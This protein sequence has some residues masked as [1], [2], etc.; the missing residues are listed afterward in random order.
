M[1]DHERAT[2]HRVQGAHVASGITFSGF[3]NVD[4]NLI[5]NAIMQQE[6][7]PLRALE[8]Q[9]TALRSRVTT[10]TLLANRISALEDAARA[11]TGQGA[12]SAFTATSTDPA[13]VG[14]SAGSLA[15]AGRYDIVV[16]E[17]ARAQVTAST[18]TTPDADT[19]VVADGGTLTIGGEA[20]AISGPMTLAELADAINAA[21]DAPARASIVQ[22]APGTFRLVL[23]ARS[24]GAANGFI[25]TN[26]LT[27]GA[28]ITFADTDGNGVSGDSPADNAVQATDAQILVNNIPVTSASNTLD[29]VI[30]GTTLTLYRRDPAATIVVDVAV[31]PSVLRSRLDAFV[32]AYNELVQFAADQSAAA[33]RGDQSSIGRDPLLRQLRSALRG[34]LTAAY[35]NSGP[36]RYLAELGVELQQDGRLE[37]NETTLDDAMAG[38]LDDVA[39][40]LTG[41]SGAP[42]ALA[43]VGALLGEYTEA[44][45]F[46]SEAKDQLNNRVERLED[47]V[48]RMQE[49]LAIRRLALQRE[50]IAA[51]EAM[52][53]LRS[54]SGSIAAFGSLL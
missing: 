5:L 13:A 20:I 28:G 4:F 8:E 21:A 16:N 47:Q 38:G 52:S 22:S 14:A 51:D 31:D 1:V 48:L 50:F 37:V 33:G 34:A 2:R 12:V 6:S 40:L 53:L 17:L 19:T 18:S 11:L 54:Q 42:G 10:F 32:S 49:R 9:Q 24:T 39:A 29:A 36:L 44:S 35:P 23:T 26:G 46:V 25:I 27:G 3:N 15:V 43:T 7:Q 45:G 41:A 30:P